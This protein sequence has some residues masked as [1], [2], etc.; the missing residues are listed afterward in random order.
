MATTTLAQTADRKALD[1]VAVVS[2]RTVAAPSITALAAIFLAC[3]H[4][5]NTILWDY[6]TRPPAY[7]A[8]APPTKLK[9]QLLTTRPARDS[10]APT[11]H[12]SLNRNT[13][14]PLCAPKNARTPDLEFNNLTPQ[15]TEIL[16][17]N[18][19]PFAAP[20]LQHCGATHSGASR[21]T[22]PDIR[23]RAGDMHIF[24]LTN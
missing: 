10:R 20:M 2:S 19:K 13:P 17:R 14:A 24:G 18:R 5:A 21:A 4:V 9:K 15:P 22:R 3:E 1:L 12:D 23:D 11:E 6:N 16:R 8:G 7:K